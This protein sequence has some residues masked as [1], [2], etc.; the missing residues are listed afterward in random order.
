MAG[1]ADYRP[2]RKFRSTS[3]PQVM[4]S[5]DPL[6]KRVAALLRQAPADLLTVAEVGRTAPPV[7]A[8]IP[9]PFVPPGAAVEDVFPGEQRR[10]AFGSHFVCRRTV[11]SLIPTAPRTVRHLRDLQRAST[12]WAASLPEELQRLLSVPM[13]QVC[14]L[15]LETA[16]LSAAPAFLIGLLGVQGGTL[17]AEQ[18]FARDYTEETS[19]LTE[20]AQR[21]RETA[22]VVTFNGKS[23]DVPCLRDRMNYYGLPW[24]ETFSHVDLLH[25]ARRRW[26]DALPDC[27]LQTLETRICRRRRTDDIPGHQIPDRYHDYV[28]TRDAAL[29]APILHHNLLD[30]VTMVELLAALLRP[31]E[32]PG[33]KPQP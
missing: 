32:T 25:H 29:V 4:P 28:D 23:F 15:D 30:L 27:R 16:G 2:R 5:R 10:T 26:K 33:R 31:T 13:E 1:S 3:I 18:F 8:T 14:F 12:Q 6:Y 22:V 19:A 11:E 20:A 17:T 21:L 9:G 7:A 24:N